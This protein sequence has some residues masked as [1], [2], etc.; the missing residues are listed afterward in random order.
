MTFQNFKRKKQAFLKFWG[1]E[2]PCT[3]LLPRIYDLYTCAYRL[4]SQSSEQSARRATV[5]CTPRKRDETKT[6]HEDTRR[7][8]PVQ[9]SRIV[10]GY[11]R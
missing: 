10:H 4:E 11:V 6:E 2:I 5:M 9:S 7:S 1:V 8:N 3:P